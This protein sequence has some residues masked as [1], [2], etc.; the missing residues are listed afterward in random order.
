MSLE[1][2]IVADFQQLLTEH[3]VEARWKT[4]DLDVLASRVRKDQQLDMGGFVE[5]PDLSLRVLKSAFPGPLPKF[6]ERIEVDGTA[7]RI[8]KV[9]NHPRSPLLILNLTTPDE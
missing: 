7:Y 6:G 5:S 2:D 4:L 1:S 9:G 8:A 3:G